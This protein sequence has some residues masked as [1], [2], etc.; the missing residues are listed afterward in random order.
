[1][2]IGAAAAALAAALCLSPARAE[3]PPAPAPAAAPA[4]PKPA[5]AVEW[6]KDLDAA[7]AAAKEKS[8]RILLVATEDFYPSEPCT[9][10]EKA[11]AEPAAREA[12]A[13]FVPLRVV[14]KEG[15]EVSRTL[16]LQ[17]LGHPY[18]ALL[19]A[20]GKVVAALRGAFGAEAWAKEM[21]RLAAA[22]DAWEA[23]RA[24]AE[25]TPGDARAL[26]DLSEALRDL[27]RVREA[28]DVLARA[29]NADPEDRARLAAQFRFRRLEAS[30]EDRMAAQDFDG[31]RALLDAYEKEF[32]NSPL[33]PW[34]G[35]YRALTR[36]WRGE[37][38]GALEDLKEI[39]GSAKDPALAALARE[40]ASAL[41]KLIEK[42]K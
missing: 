6:A 9:R 15:V 12:L 2:R 4:E 32:P 25:N 33:K 39:A 41:E 37:A 31:A 10:L 5:A 27:G 42:R 20:E 24:A 22:A 11:V 21:R 1:V 29:E 14:E 3:E 13:G 35:F 18:T 34:V 19:D 7:K 28:D 16:G 26:F 23:K 40:K 30:V 17:D 36:A 38:D 8:R